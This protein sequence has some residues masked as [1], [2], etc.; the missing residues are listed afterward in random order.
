VDEVQKV[1]VAFVDC[2]GGVS[3]E[4]IEPLTVDSPVTRFLKGGGGLHHLCYEVDD[5]DEAVDDL[6]GQGALLVCSPVP[7]AAFN[8]KKIAFL[9]LYKKSLIEI[10]ERGKNE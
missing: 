4:L 3:L 10:V 8:G 2:G 1:K 7:A 9:Y 6:R 5:I